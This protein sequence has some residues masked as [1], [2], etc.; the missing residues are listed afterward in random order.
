MAIM[1]A[2]AYGANVGGIGTKI[3]T[4]P[5]AQ[6]SGFMEQ[7]GIE[8][9]FLQFMAVGLPFVAHVPAGRLVGALADRPAGRAWPASSA[10]R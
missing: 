10:R 2:I 5:N 1:L 4:A 7:L 6:F 9:C 3:G 8:I